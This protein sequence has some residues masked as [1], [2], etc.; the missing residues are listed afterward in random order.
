MIK[1]LRITS[2]VVTAILVGVLIKY[3]VFP[4]DSN[5]GGDQRVE[6]VLDSPG[7]IELFKQTNT[8]ARATGNQTSPLVLEAI[9]YASYLSPP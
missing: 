3:F 8:H 5:V 4:T 7:V 6:K 9:A 1:T 2:V